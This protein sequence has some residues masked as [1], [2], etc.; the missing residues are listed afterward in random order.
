MGLIKAAT[1]MIGGGLADQWVE[2][3]EPDDMSDTTV[4]TKGV[5]VRKD[6]KRGSNRKGTED[7]LTDG[8]VVHVYPNM[9]MLLVDGGKIIDYTA[10][11]GYYTIKNDS[12]SSMAEFR[13]SVKTP[14][15]WGIV[16]VAIIVVLVAVLAGIFKK[17][18]RR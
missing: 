7:V 3:I 17:F 8:S 4:M 13:V 18:G 6:D 16:A 11:E 9:M 12:A 2:V 14:T 15:T 5:K 1:S 10:E